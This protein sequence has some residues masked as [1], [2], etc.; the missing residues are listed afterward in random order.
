MSNNSKRLWFILK[1]ACILVSGLS[2]AYGIYI[3]LAPDLA[4]GNR[5][6]YGALSFVTAYSSALLA[7]FVEVFYRISK[8]TQDLL[9]S[10]ENDRNKIIAYQQKVVEYQRIHHTKK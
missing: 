2:L 8:Q 10:V 6:F 1:I 4:P 3:V 5:L 9:S 7:I